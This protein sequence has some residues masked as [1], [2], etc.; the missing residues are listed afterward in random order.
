MAAEFSG[1]IPY[2]VNF[3]IVIGAALFYGRA[4]IKKFVYQRHERQRDLIDSAAAA[5]KNAEKRFLEIQENL[6]SLGDESRRLLAEAEADAKAEAQ[7]IE[8]RADADVARVKK[9]VERI[10]AGEVEQ[11]EAGMRKLVVDLAADKATKM[12]RGQMKKEDH[13]AILRVAK[14]SIEAETLNG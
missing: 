7:T 10:L 6:R 13:S 5:K 14:R 11:R 12:L 9:D 2:A 3:S 1:L 8:K 4:P